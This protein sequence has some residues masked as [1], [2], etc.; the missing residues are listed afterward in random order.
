MAIKINSLELEHVKRIKA[1]KLE[2]SKNGLTIIGG[3]N[4][5]GKSSVLDAIAWALGGNKFKPSRPQRDGSM[6][7]PYLRV[8]LSNGLIVE[9]KGKTVL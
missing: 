9:R 6:T 3:R 2:P 5:Q 4:E 8:E 1:I 7:D